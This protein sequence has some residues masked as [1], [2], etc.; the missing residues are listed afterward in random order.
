MEERAERLRELQQSL[1]AKD[2]ELQQRKREIK[3]MRVQTHKYA[4]THDYNEAATRE[5]LIDV[6]LRESGWDPKGRNVAEYEVKGM[7]NKT[8]VGFVDYVLWDDNGKPIGLVEAKRTTRNVNEGQQ[9]AKLY[10]DCLEDKYGI[11][12]IIFLSNGYKIW[13][14][15]DQVYPPRPIQGFYTK[16]SLQKLFSRSK[17]KNR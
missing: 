8:G 6:M 12:P 1:E 3:Q 10:A 9:Q 4:D 15:D 16:E 7:P 5:L 11:R 2:E 17:I 13:L 14:W